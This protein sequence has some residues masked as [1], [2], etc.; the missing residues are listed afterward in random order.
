MGV[1]KLLSLPFSSF[2]LIS[3]SQVHAVC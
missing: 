1:G 2:L 3:I